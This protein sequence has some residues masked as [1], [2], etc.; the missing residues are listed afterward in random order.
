[1]TG[2]IIIF[3]SILS[4]IYLLF[5]HKLEIYYRLCTEA[6]Q[7]SERSGSAPAKQPWNLIS[8]LSETGLLPTGWHPVPWPSKR[9]WE[10]YSDQIYLKGPIQ[11]CFPTYKDTPLGITISVW[12]IFST[13]SLSTLFKIIKIT[14]TFF[15]KYMMVQ[16][17][18]TTR[19]D[20]SCSKVNVLFME[21]NGLC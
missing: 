13:S 16:I 17:F 4:V 11:T 19:Q 14:S 7:G 6:S 10:K 2:T 12:C 1:M 15:P 8:K 3:L 5:I 21:Q 9:W 18:Y 20:V